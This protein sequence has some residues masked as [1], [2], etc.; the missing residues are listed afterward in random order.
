MQAGRLQ[1]GG[2]LVEVILDGLDLDDDPVFLEKITHS[3]QYTDFTA[4]PVG[5]EVAAYVAGFDPTYCV[6]YRW[7]LIRVLR[8]SR[9]GAF[10]SAHKK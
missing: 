2:D 8:C 7:E 10:N 1:Q 6:Q 4:F 5:L 9:L 3:L